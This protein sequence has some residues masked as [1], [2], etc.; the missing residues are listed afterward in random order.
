MRHITD[1]PADPALTH[2]VDSEPVPQARVYLVLSDEERARGFVRPVRQT[3][4]H[5]G[6]GGH[7]IDPV[8]RARHGRVSP[9]CGAATRMGRELA[10]TYARDPKFYRATYCVGCS[11]HRPVEEFIWEDGEVLGS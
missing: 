11:M 7:E 8:N 9:G 6:V 3:Y 2:G 4:I 1:D 5:V 10:E